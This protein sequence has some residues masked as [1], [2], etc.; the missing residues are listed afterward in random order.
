MSN[1]QVWLNLLHTCYMA[2]SALIA[3]FPA[4]FTLS[5]SVVSWEWAN[6]LGFSLNKHFP[7]VS[8]ILCL[9]DTT[10][11]YHNALLQN[12]TLK[13]GSQTAE[14]LYFV[15]VNTYN[16]LKV[17]FMRRKSLFD[18]GKQYV[19]LTAYCVFAV[20]AARND[21]MQCHKHLQTWKIKELQA[22]G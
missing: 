11:G 6:I 19:I 9:C 21:E 3:S 8:L 7:T 22:A 10:R 15:N 18:W 5:H 17:F 14:K 16:L 12:I 2:S 13:V 4:A 20:S 1:I